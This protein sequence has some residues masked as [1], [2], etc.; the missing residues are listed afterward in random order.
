MHILYL[1]DDRKMLACLRRALAARGIRMTCFATAGELLAIAPSSDADV[2]LLDYHLSDTDGLTVFKALSAKGVTTPCVLYTGVADEKQRTLAH[3][4]GLAAV[5][6]KSMPPGEL[7][8]L[9]RNLL[10][11][12]LGPEAAPARDTPRGITL[13]PESGELT[14]GSARAHLRKQQLSFLMLLARTDSGFPRQEIAPRLFG[15]DFP[16]DPELAHRM[17][18]RI[19]KAV[20]RLRS[21]LGDFERL[22]DCQAARV[23]LTAK[24]TIVKSGTYRAVAP[25]D[26]APDVP[27]TN[28]PHLRSG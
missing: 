22:L 19:A 16:A 4:L 23:R 8:A 11:P 21:A 5:V 15:V 14:D 13:D 17:E 6:P 24:V 2:I 26:D 3:D 10:R 27:A 7:A 25:S 18:D 1:D 9:L 28:T 20:R 12:R